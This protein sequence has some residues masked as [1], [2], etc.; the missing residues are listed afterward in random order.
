MTISEFDANMAV[1][2]RMKEEHAKVKVVV[3]ANTVE[4]AQRLYEN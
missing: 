1:L 3:V 2:N 4:E